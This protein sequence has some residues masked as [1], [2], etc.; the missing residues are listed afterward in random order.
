MKLVDDNALKPFRTPGRCEICG[1][2]C[3][4]REPHHIYPRGSGQVDH[5]WNCL[6]VGA[7]KPK[8]ECFC[9]ADIG[10]GIWRGQVVGAKRV[11][12]LCLQIAAAREGINPE[13]ITAEVYRIRNLPQP[14][15]GGPESHLGRKK[16]RSALQEKAN[17]CRRAAWKEARRRQKE[18]KKALKAKNK[19]KQ[20]R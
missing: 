6:A 13:A 7:S 15:G 3:K 14:R 5:P 4:K 19:P 9:H 17:A 16:P 18:F 1:R 11:Q 20:G 10:N 2:L 8:P 12:E